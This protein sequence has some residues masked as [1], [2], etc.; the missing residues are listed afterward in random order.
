MHMSRGIFQT[1]AVL[2][3]GAIAYVWLFVEGLEKT[4]SIVFLV[5]LFILLSSEYIREG[6]SQ[7]KPE[8]SQKSST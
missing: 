6:F 1:L 7:K 8:P 2:I 4:I 3:I 5:S